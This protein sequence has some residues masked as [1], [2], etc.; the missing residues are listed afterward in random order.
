MTNPSATD[1]GTLYPIAFS[2]TNISRIDIFQPNDG[3]AYAID[4][5]DFTSSAA[6]P[7][8]FS[9]TLGLVAMGGICGLSRLRKHIDNRKAINEISG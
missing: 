9:P 3:W 1:S 8:E 7:F 5:L 6:V 2:S 4:N